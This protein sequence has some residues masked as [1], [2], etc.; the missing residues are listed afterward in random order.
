[1]LYFSNYM[2]SQTAIARKSE[3]ARARRKD[4]EKRRNIHANLPTIFLKD[5]KI[6]RNTKA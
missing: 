6:H 4:Y 5:G 1:M 3:K 2:R